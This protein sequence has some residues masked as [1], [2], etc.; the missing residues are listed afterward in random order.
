MVDC[1]MFRYTYIY[2]NESMY[3]SMYVCNCET[4]DICVGHSIFTYIFRQKN[5]RQSLLVT[6]LWLG[7][8]GPTV[9][10]TAATATDSGSDNS[11]TAG[12]SP[13][14][15]SI[16]VRVT[17][18]TTATTTTTNI[19]TLWYNTPLLHYYK[20]FQS[21]LIKPATTLMPST[22]NSTTTTATTAIIITTTTT[23]TTTTTPYNYVLL[24][25]YN[26]CY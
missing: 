1:C 7:W 26:N 9:W 16:Q 22:T 12:R 21:H 6:T 5:L 24:M 3:L 23:T 10:T 19:T 15:R 11:E 2:R 4:S 18:T 25:L 13:W 17:N 20:S 8:T 14:G